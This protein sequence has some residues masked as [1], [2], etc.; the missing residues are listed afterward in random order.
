M[1]MPAASLLG[2]Q[3]CRACQAGSK[4]DVR[5]VSIRLGSFVCEGLSPTTACCKTAMLL[6][7]FEACQVMVN[8]WHVVRTIGKCATLLGRSSA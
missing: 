5:L 7:R 3:L 4:C 8:S 2:T 1:E 6:L